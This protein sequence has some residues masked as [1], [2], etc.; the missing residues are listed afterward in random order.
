MIDPI[1]WRL[2]RLPKAGTLTAADITTRSFNITDIGSTTLDVEIRNC[3][4]STFLSLL[5]RRSSMT[6]LITAR[7]VARTLSMRL[8]GARNGLRNGRKGAG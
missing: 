1:R 2:D 6:G 3:N 4:T 7:A 5:C 8:L